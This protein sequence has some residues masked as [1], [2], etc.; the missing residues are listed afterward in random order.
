MDKGSQTSLTLSRLPRGGFIVSDD[1]GAFGRHGMLT[2]QH[3]AT[4]SI[5]E[6]LQFMRDAINP[7]PP[8]QEPAGE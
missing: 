2:T 5:D 6:A 8:Q 7:I 1:A 3:L 4:S